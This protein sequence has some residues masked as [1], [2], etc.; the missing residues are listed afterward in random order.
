M[1]TKTVRIIEYFVIITLGLLML[2]PILWLISSSLKENSE[3]LSSSFSLIPKTV[4]FENYANGWRGFGG[5]TFATFFTNSLIVA[6]LTTLGTV[7]SSVL[8]A[9]AFA[10][11]RFFG[12]DFWFACMICT[13][14]LPSQI[15]LLPQYVI[16]NKL[17]WINTFLPLIIPAFG[18]NAFFIFLVTQF[19][20][21]LPLELDEAAIIDGCSR[22]SLFFRITLP[23]TSP[24]MITTI[25]IQFYWKWDE[26][27]EPLLFLGRPERYT[28]SL[29]IKAFSDQ[30][31]TTE[32]GN[33]FAMSTL[34]L[35]PVFVIFLLFNKQLVEGISTTGLKG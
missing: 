14:M 18:G 28:V 21:G 7:I 29:A 30:T 20:K 5:I 3:I 26:F 11:L 9:Y 17:G 31:S 6:S 27:L 32:Y 1:R 22:Y 12:K 25:V 2:Y 15:V 16:F 33:M 13:L 34:A 8:V 19:M 24:A 10:R 4:H 23:L 35:V